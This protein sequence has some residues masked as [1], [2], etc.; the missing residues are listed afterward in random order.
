VVVVSFVHRHVCEVFYDTNELDVQVE[1]SDGAKD[2]CAGD[3]YH[4]GTASGCPGGAMMNV[5]SP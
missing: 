3:P 4:I 1:T 5:L 2:S